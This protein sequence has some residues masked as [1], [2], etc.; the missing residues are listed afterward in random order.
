[1]LSTR[2]STIVPSK[3]PHV[4]PSSKYPVSLAILGEPM[5]KRD[6]TL[7]ARL[8]QRFVTSFMDSIRSVM[9]TLSSFSG[10]VIERQM[11]DALTEPKSSY[12]AMKAWHVVAW[13][14][15]FH[16]YINPARKHY[17]DLSKLVDIIKTDADAYYLYA[18]YIL[19]KP[20]MIV[21]TRL[22]AMHPEVA[23]KYANHCKNLEVAKFVNGK[24]LGW[25]FVW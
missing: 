11:Y 17:V 7:R 22:K 2:K 18:V 1:M 25:L 4:P 6:F 12:S 3:F 13:H 19:Q 14:T 15:M 10:Y 20:S 16:P 24:D 21:Y 23:S 5:S 9:S 8:S